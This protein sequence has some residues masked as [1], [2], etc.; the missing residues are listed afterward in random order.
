MPLQKLSCQHKNQFYWMQIIFCTGTKCLWLA[1]YVNN[2]LVWHKKFGLAQ[3]ILGHVKGQGIRRV[4]KMTYGFFSSSLPPQKRLFGKRSIFASR[5]VTNIKLQKRRNV[6]FLSIPLPM[7]SKWLV[8]TKCF[9]R[10]VPLLNT[11]T[12]EPVLLAMTSHNWCCFPGKKSLRPCRTRNYTNPLTWGK[13]WARPPVHPR[14]R[15]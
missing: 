7:C 10:N 13:P 2:F 6:Q 5:A 3:N 15:E 14:Q 12:F 9:S 4:F 11:S 8:L 1:Q